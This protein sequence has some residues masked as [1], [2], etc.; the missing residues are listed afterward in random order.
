MWVSSFVTHIIFTFT[1]QY[2]NTLL[3]PR[4]FTRYFRIW[5]HHSWKYSIELPGSALFHPLRCTFHPVFELGLHL[6]FTIIMVKDIDDLGMLFTVWCSPMHVTDV[7]PSNWCVFYI[8]DFI[9]GSASAHRHSGSPAAT[10]RRLEVPWTQCWSI[11][12]QWHDWPR[13]ASW[14]LKQ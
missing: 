3:R 14:L 11:N 8:W 10:C 4:N 12:R 13:W 6:K 2:Q 1:D 7:W 5:P 9:V